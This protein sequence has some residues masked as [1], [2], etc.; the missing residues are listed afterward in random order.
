MH[1]RKRTWMTS[2]S[3]GVQKQTDGT[4]MHK[5]P[6]NEMWLPMGGQLETFMYVFPPRHKENGKKVKDKAEGFASICPHIQ[7]KPTQDGF[8][9]HDSMS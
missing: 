2:K 8:S 1:G 3:L 4:G 5:R 7:N 9:C 6:E